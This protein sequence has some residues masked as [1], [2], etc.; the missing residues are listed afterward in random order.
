[1]LNIH[2]DMEDG[3]QILSTDDFRT[4]TDGKQD[5]QKIPAVEFDHVSLSYKGAGGESLTD[6]SFRAMRGQTIGLSV[7][8]DQ[9]NPHWS[10]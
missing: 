3:E 4:N 8:Q 10:I 9:E 2:P 7:E 1:M 5:V 6:I